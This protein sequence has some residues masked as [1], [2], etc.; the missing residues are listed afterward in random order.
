MITPEQRQNVMEQ[1]TQRHG[2]AHRARIEQG[3][4]QVAQRWRE[5]DGDAGVFEQFCLTHFAADEALR[6]QIFQRFQKNLEV[7]LGHLH[8]VYR[9]LNW[10]LHVDTGPKLEI[11]NLFASYDVFAHVIDDMFTT[12]LA[13]V[14]LLNFPLATLEEKS[15]WGHEWTRRHWAEV[16]L[17]ENFADRIPGD[18]KQQ[19]TAAYTAAEDYVYS[20]FIPLGRVRD[21]TGAPLFAEGL[22]LISHWG[23]R[24]ELKGQ[25][26]NPDGFP[27]Q[28]MIQQI[29]NRIIT[30]EIPVEVLRNDGVE[31]RPF[32]NQVYDRHSGKTVS[33]SPEGTG[34]YEILLKTFH[35]EQ[36]VD[37]H[38]PDTPSLIDR[39]FRKD[40]EILE[41]EVERL[42]TTVLSAPVLQDIAGLIRRRLGRELQ[43]FDLWYSG[44]KSGGNVQEAELDQIVQ[45]RFPTVRDFEKKLPEV[46]MQLGFSKE[47]AH[48]LQRYI[49][50]DAARGAGHAMGAKMRHDTAHLRTRA[51]GGRMNYKGFDTAM[52]ELGHTV[53]QVFSMNDVDHYTLEGVPNTAFTEAFAFV[54]QARGMEVLCLT[55]G[56]ASADQANILHEMWQTAEIAG[57]SLLDM[58]IWRWLYAHPDADAIALKEAV[59]QLAKEVWNEFFAPIYGVKDQILLAIYS[60]ILYCGMYIPDY[61]LGHIIANQIADHL[62]RHDFAAEVERMCRL[63]RLAPQVWMREAVGAPISAQPMIRAAAAAVENL[64]VQEI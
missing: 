12:R 13:F 35:A 8:M 38:T 11:D 33:A 32:S 25:Y 2:A 41:A 50:V 7:L 36:L 57:V 45:S 24:D 15:A 43:P 59:L 39:R 14:A 10:P 48:Y 3:V 20:Y 5:S 30:Q 52:H 16:R 9:E 49:R 22:S 51:A 53:E 40:R 23:L 63:G 1:L 37:P 29:M 62:R 55:N 44:F 4:S 19:R 47:K 64:V 31:W 34:R 56:E 54:F 28:L 18:V 61:A 42:L 27:R 6:D 46:L 58:R 17:A 21:E 60:H 26:A